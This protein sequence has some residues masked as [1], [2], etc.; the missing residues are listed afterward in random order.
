MTSPPARR[1]RAAGQAVTVALAC[2]TIALGAAFGVAACV[3]PSATR[4][5]APT[6]TD[7]ALIRNAVARLCHAISGYTV[8]DLDRAP[9][10][11][12]I[13]YLAGLQGVPADLR[14]AA[15]G[16]WDDARVRDLDDPRNRAVADSRRGD[17]LAA[18]KAKG[19]TVG[20]QATDQPPRR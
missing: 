7:P 11:G 18:C 9:V 5:P 1:A 8:D 15:T 20:E 16:Y 14:A 12:D 3:E 19:W 4:A 10:E 17:V 2:V 13:G 6:I